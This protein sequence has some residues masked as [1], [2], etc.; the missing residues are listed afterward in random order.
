MQDDR[1]NDGAIVTLDQCLCCTRYEPVIGQVYAILDEAGSNVSQVIDDIQMSYMS[2]E[3]FK[4]RNKIEEMQTDLLF[5]DLK[6]DSSEIPDPFLKNKWKDTLAE[7]LAKN[8]NDK[9]PLQPGQIKPDKEENKEEDKDYK[10][11]FVMDWNPSLLET[12]SSAINKYDIEFTE[13]NK[14]DISSGSQGID[15][16]AFVDSR[17]LAIEYERLEFDVNKYTVTGFSSGGSSSG[18]SFG[19]GSA[20]ARNKIVDYVLN[21]VKLAQEG[22]GKYSQDYRTNHGDKAINGI[23]YWDCSSLVESAYA[24][25]GIT[26]IGDNT[27]TQYPKCLDSAGGLLFPISEVKD[28]L[29]GDMV[30][31]KTPPIPTDKT[32]FQ[33]VNYS[34]GVIIPHVAIYIGDNKYAHAAYEGATPTEV[35]INNLTD[36]DQ[37]MCFGRVKSLIELDKQASIGASG[38]GAWNREA[39]GIND[40]LWNASAVAESNA[41]GMIANMEKYKYK[42]ILVATSK[43]HG[44]DPYFIGALIAIE[45]TGNP[46]SGGGYPGILQCTN[47]YATSTL[48]GIQ[49]NLNISLPDITNKAN[50]LKKYGWTEKNMHLL[51]TAHNCG[52]YGTT[53]AL[54]HTNETHP[55]VAV[56]MMGKVLN[57]NTSTIGQ[58]APVIYDYSVKFQQQNGWNNDEKRTYATK[59]LRAY[60]ILYSKKVLG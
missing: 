26:G 44:Y 38:S 9:V 47:G 42:D 27:R 59:V 15:R 45:T 21:A 2:L 32:S 51:A 3:E 53:C 13:L 48:E 6:K 30:W 43:K 7:K 22:K 55:H 11:G 16:D 34:D 41:S 40:D 39:H 5:A 19:M 17:Q 20:E 18:G 52:Q 58:V 8:K 29:P 31:F 36:W 10:N 33:T 49:D 14:E 35:K 56:P 25:A 12:Q 46:L 50:H 24:S 60:N 28:A 23:H 37:I 57:L 54:G 4:T 1:I